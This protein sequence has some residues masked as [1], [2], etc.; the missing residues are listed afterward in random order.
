MKILFVVSE[1]FFSEPMG[2][3]QLSAIG[4][5]SG[6]LTR[7]VSLKDH[8]LEDMLDSFSPD[9]VCYSV[10]SADEEV[11]IQADKVVLG[12]VETSGRKI[13]RIMGGPHPTYFPEILSKMDL[14]AICVGDGDNALATIL[15][16]LQLGKNLFDIPN[17]VPKGGDIN[18]MEKELV[19]DMDS[20]PY[21]DRELLYRD[22]PD[23]LDQGIRS[24]QTQRGCPFKCSYCFNH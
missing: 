4:K 3:M 7:L 14:D 2:V 10:M 23:L 9:L 5:K 21:L 19:H 12:W 22:S 15:E 6:H 18:G 17:I 11:F 16:R 13:P 8:S 1:L 20:L 24:F